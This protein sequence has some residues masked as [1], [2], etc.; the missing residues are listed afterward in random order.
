[1]KKSEISNK[2][3][4]GR[5][6]YVNKYCWLVKTLNYSS[7]E[8][9]RYCDSKFRGCLFF[10][11]MTISLISIF[12][13]FSLFILIEGRLPK[14]VVFTTFVLV[15]VYGYFFS[16]STEKIIKANFAQRTAKEALEKLTKSLEDQVEQKTKDLKERAEH[17][18]KLLIM[19][20]EFLDIAS[21][22]LKTPVSVILGV[23]SMFKEGNM[24][25]LPKEQQLKFLDNIFH[26][27][28]KLS[29]ITD[30]ILRASEMDTDG[31]D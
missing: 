12:F 24:D 16:E 29:V 14:L 25:K 26:K 23:A 1:M 3:K 18:K 21:H 17:L 8:R 2:E 22:Q 19:R 6:E 9:C 7:S 4:I 28:K 15:I 31:L 27:A 10:Q 13:I 11:Y 20:S 30:D 5:P